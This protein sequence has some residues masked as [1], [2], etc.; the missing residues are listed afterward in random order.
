MAGLLNGAMAG[1]GQGM[2][3]TGQFLMRVTA[4]EQKE[5]RLRQYEM[6]REQRQAQRQDAIR[7]E[8]RQWQQEDY[9]T[10]RG[11]AV[12]DR[13]VGFQQQVGLLQMREAGADRRTGMQI[14][15]SREQGRNDWQ[16]L[17]TQ[18]G[19]YIQFSP[20]RN[21]YRDANLPEGVSAGGNRDLTDREKLTINM[22]SDER[23]SIMENSMGQ[24][25]AEQA[26]RL[27]EIEQQL[28]SMGIGSPS[29]GGGLLERVLNEVGGGQASPAP[30][31][32][33][34][35]SSAPPPRP[36]AASVDDIE[37]RVRSQR[38]EAQAAR[39]TQQQTQQ[40]ER[41]INQIRGLSSRMGIGPGMSN[42][43]RQRLADQVRQMADQL[44]QENNLD[45]RQLERL[46]G[47]I[48][49]VVQYGG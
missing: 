18:D 22:L 44:M 25:S 4:D 7:A 24:P 43:D 8:D 1:L 16:M 9:Q 32:Q 35:G 46:E 5:K 37:N 3:E 19:R 34:Q 23:K 47:A 28:Q 15:A 45:D 42:A 10:Q 6:E 14:A 40:V 49:N 39:S 29:S 20:S 33:Q 21:E 31:T 2:A 13:D 41:T 27:G 36:G 11:H 30:A 12:E 48:Q 26:Q 38:S 17:P